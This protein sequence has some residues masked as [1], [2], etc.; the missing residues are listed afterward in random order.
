MNASQGIQNPYPV[1]IL[2]LCNTAFI[3]RRDPLAN[4]HLNKRHCLDRTVSLWPISIWA[5]QGQTNSS[6]LGPVRLCHSHHRSCTVWNITTIESSVIPRKEDVVGVLPPSSGNTMLLRGNQIDDFCK[7]WLC[8]QVKD[9]K[10][11]NPVLSYIPPWYGGAWIRKGNP[12]NAS[13]NELQATHT[14]A[15][16]SV[17]KYCI[18]LSCNGGDIL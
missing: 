9:T 7:F 5:V 10:A 4:S 8:F 16:V 18:S 14:I 13:Y 17:L 3:V 6:N 11:L 12:A 1:R 2:R 15:I